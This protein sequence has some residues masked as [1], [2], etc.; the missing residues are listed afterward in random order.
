MFQNLPLPA[1]QE[2]R[3]NS[4]MTPCIVMKNDMVLYHQVSLFFPES[5]RLRSLPQSETAKDPVKQNRL[6]YRCYRVVNTGDMNK[7]RRADGVRRLVYIWQKVINKG[8]TILKV[9]KVVSL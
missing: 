1:A 2:I 9:H 5:M 6:T 3:D 8:M 4:G 7:D